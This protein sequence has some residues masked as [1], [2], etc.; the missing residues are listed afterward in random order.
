MKLLWI[1]LAVWSNIAFAQEVSPQNKLETI[2]I[3][4]MRSEIP[5]TS[6]VHEQFWSE[7]RNISNV[8]R[9]EFL[10]WTSSAILEGQAYQIEV[11]E[12]ALLSFNK[13]KV[14]KTEKMIFLEKSIK[15]KMLR[16]IETSN[17]TDETKKVL[18]ASF[19]ARHQHS[20]FNASLVLEAASKHQHINLPG[21][22]N[23]EMNE[24]AIRAIA[25]SIK[26][27]FDRIKKLLNPT[28]AEGDIANT[29]ASSRLLAHPQIDRELQLAH[30]RAMRDQFQR[31]LVGPTPQDVID[32]GY[33]EAN[34]R[35]MQAVAADPNKLEMLDAAIRGNMVYT[36]YRRLLQPKFEPEE[37]YEPEFSLAPQDSSSALL[38]RMATAKSRS[39][40]QQYL[41]DFK[42][43]QLRQKTLMSQGRV[44]GIA[45]SIAVE[46][47]FWSTIVYIAVRIF[48]LVRRRQLK[49]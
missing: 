11:W 1:L 23:I 9:A 15:S 14:W 48:S 26:S 8:E 29:L 41:N 18:S 46:L 22:Q 4:V 3:G 19:E 20:I 33:R 7:L 39:E 32:S 16:Y 38:K 2:F 35:T 45:L 27:T 17:S 21:M 28:W 24:N 31:G 6:K 42:Y 13:K 44:R 40:T 36:F 47:M 25:G 37:G 5:L 12:S 43:E 49:I 30:E 10:E 34:E